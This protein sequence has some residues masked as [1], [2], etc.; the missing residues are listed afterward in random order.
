MLSCNKPVN[1]RV[2]ETKHRGCGIEHVEVKLVPLTGHISRQGHGL[3]DTSLDLAF[4]L[5]RFG[6]V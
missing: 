5:V 6:V 3:D 2:H 1:G 4:Y